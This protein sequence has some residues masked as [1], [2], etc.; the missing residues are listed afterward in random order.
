MGSSCAA[1]RSRDTYRAAGESGTCRSISN[2]RRLSFSQDAPRIKDHRYTKLTSL[3]AVLPALRRSVMPRP[4]PRARVVAPFRCAPL[5]P[6][7]RGP[8]LGGAGPQALVVRRTLLPP[9]ASASLQIPPPGQRVAR[10]AVARSR[11]RFGCARKA[12]PRT[13]SPA[14]HKARATIK[15]KSDKRQAQPEALAS[16]H[17]HQGQALARRPEP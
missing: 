5:R 13:L 2:H 8:S 9:T 15:S 10:I 16:S 7:S 4:G 3:Y 12:N 14:E 6:E 11:R 1:Q 17:A